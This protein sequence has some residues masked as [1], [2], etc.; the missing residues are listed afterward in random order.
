MIQNQHVICF[1]A[2]KE[3]KNEN[4]WRK[5]LEETLIES[6]QILD[7]NFFCKHGIKMD[8]GCQTC[9]DNEA[10]FV[11]PC[12]KCGRM[13]E[14]LIHIRKYWKRSEP[15]C[16]MGC[17]ASKMFGCISQA[18]QYNKDGVAFCFDWSQMSFL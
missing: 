3:T 17:D 7:L 4:D 6:R 15:E 14:E 2:N 1:K 13:V 18:I 10:T 12:I 11:A 9:I 5:N 16:T 8:H